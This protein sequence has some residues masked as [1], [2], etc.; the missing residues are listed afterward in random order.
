MNY[1][2]IRDIKFRAWGVKTKVMYSLDPNDDKGTLRDLLANDGW[3]VMQYTGLKDK[4][5]KEILE[6]D[7]IAYF[8]HYGKAYRKKPIMEQVVWDAEQ[9][10]FSPF[11]RQCDGDDMTTFFI[12]E[13]S[14]EVLGNIYENKELLDALHQ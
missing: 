12:K 7:I 6:G 5:G 8:D 2:N 3:R 10:G 1:T 13:N 4:N 11:C 9:A 14:V